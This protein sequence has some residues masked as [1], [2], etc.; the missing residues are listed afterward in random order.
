MNREAVCDL[1]DQYQRSFHML[2]E[3][4]QRFDDEQ[5]VKGISYFQ[6]PARQAMH[7]FDCLDYYFSGVDG[8]HFH[9]GY[10]FSGGWWELNEDQLPT[11][12]S[13]LAYAGE[14]QQRVL[15][16]F[17]RLSDD[18]LSK[19]FPIADGSGATLLGH[20]VY[21]LRHTIHHQGQLSALAVYH[22]LEGGSWE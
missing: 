5:W 14:V 21:A 22:G 8:D 6:T 1:V 18:D 12:E 4:I 11:R 3:E 7:I 2:T 19:P 9:W 10:R 15:A 17:D 20:Y 16:E 13:V